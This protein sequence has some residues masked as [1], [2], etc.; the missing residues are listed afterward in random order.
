[1]STFTLIGG[2]DEFDL[3]LKIARREVAAVKVTV[4]GGG[5]SS[6]SF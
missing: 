3:D 1:M 6:Q 5:Y 2:K 4:Q